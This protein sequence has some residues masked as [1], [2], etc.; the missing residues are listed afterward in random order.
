M[1]GN[2]R[3]GLTPE[4]A[5]TEGVRVHGDD[6]RPRVAYVNPNEQYIVR[7]VA[8]I[9]VI[10]GGVYPRSKHTR[11]A[12]LT[13]IASGK[14]PEPV[15]RARQYARGITVRKRRHICRRPA[16]R[17]T[18][19]VA[20]MSTVAVR[21]SI[22]RPGTLRDTT[23][24]WLVRPSCQGRPPDGISDVRAR[25]IMFICLNV[26]IVISEAENQKSR[27]SKVNFRPDALVSSG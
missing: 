4:N 7:P 23:A 20:V 5:L 11:A 18:S 17:D 12:T 26:I 27:F 6:I 14:H 19:P 1:L 9:V 2:K 22:T 21:G 25:Y 13:R 16:L 15:W 3:R 10:G 24:T 8:G